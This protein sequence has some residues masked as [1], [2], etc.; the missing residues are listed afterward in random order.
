MPKEWTDEEVQKEIAEAIQI[1]RED[2]L[3]TF[4]RNRFA[5]PTT[6]PNANPNPPASG[7]NGNPTDKPKKGL[8]WGDSE[9]G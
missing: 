7:G 2:R 1:V 6:D 4:L 9:S 3:E 5:N 8:W